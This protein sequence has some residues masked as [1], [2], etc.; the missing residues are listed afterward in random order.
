[1]FDIIEVS[2][3]FTLR[4]SIQRR[5]VSIPSTMSFDLLHDLSMRRRI[6]AHQLIIQA[7]QDC[8]SMHGMLKV[9][10]AM[11]SHWMLDR[12]DGCCLHI[13]HHNLS[14]E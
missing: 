4:V 5:M 2:I 12:K 3:A 10:H 8:F 11:Y 14:I 7:S 13:I 9:F 1:L 6:K